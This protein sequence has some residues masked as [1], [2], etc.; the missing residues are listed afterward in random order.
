[1]RFLANEN[2]PGAAVIA[3]E[4]AGHDVVWVRVAAP[5]ATDPDVLAWAAGNHIVLIWGSEKQKYFCK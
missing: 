3:L 1:M 5:G 4:S 2:F